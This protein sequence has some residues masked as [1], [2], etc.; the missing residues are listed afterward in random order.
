MSCKVLKTRDYQITQHY[1]NGHSGVDVVGRGGMTDIIVAH[2]G[3]KV[4]FCQKG[5]KHNP[6]STGNLSYGNCVKIKHDNGMYTLYAH[7]ADVRVLINQRV[8][9]GQELGM[10]GNTG[11]SYG[12][13][14]HFEVYNTNN[15]RVNP[16]SYLNRDLDNLVDCTGTI[17]YQVFAKNKW[18]EEVHKAD[19]TA[20]GYAGNGVDF[21]SGLRAKPQYG[22]IFIQSHSIRSGWL[23]EI[24]SNNYKTNDT[25]DGSS[26]S[27][28]YGEPIDKI[29]IRCTKGWVAYRVKTANGWLPWVR[30]YKNFEND[31]YAGNEGEP[32]LGIQ[33]V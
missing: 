1:G 31:I 26:Y 2:S 6:G 9:Q 24:S 18:Y 4:V 19:D 23:S 33:M 25:N 16:E 14:L 29:R 7:L 22:E 32:I 27:G 8:E 11:N 30:G 28:I 10:M 21:I 17:T 20:D 12:A 15:V 3:G 13:H 5:Q